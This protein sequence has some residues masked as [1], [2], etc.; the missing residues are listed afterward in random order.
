MQCNT[1][2]VATTATTPTR[3]Q[4]A[5]RPKARLVLVTDSAPNNTLALIASGPAVNDPAGAPR[6]KPRVID[7]HRTT[8]NE[9][10]APFHRSSGAPRG[11]AET[12]CLASGG[13]GSPFRFALLLLL[14]RC[15]RIWFSTGSLTCTALCLVAEL[16]LRHPRLRA[17]AH[18]FPATGLVIFTLELIWL[19]IP[20][21]WTEAVDV[22]AQVAEMVIP[23]VI[24]PE[25]VVCPTCLGTGRDREAPAASADDNGTCP[26]C[27]SACRC[28]RTIAGPVSTSATAITARSDPTPR[29]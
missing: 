27:S 18:R 23:A 29:E 17:I 16:A 15:V 22:I 25:I 5:A 9:A 21:T 12:R 1:A 11:D 13:M 4:G 19:E 24:E 6:L 14:A 8:A 28:G 2:V 20:W 26:K 10:M 3:D 7:P